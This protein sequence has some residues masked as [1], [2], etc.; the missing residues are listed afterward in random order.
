M[1]AIEH[2]HDA[3]HES[4][5]GA[6]PLDDCW[7]RIGTRGD[8]SCERLAQYVRCLNCPVFE[9][10]A[11]RM[12]DRPAQRAAR[13]PEPEGG[14]AAQA[15]AARQEG[16]LVFRVGAE[17]LALGAQALRYVGEARAIHSLPHRR[18]PAVLGVVNVRGV[19]TLAASLAELLRIDVT[20]D[21]TAAA[22][23]RFAT[24]GAGAAGAAGARAAT[25]R[26]LVAEWGGETTA[27]PVDDVEGVAYF[28]K[29]D[30]LS[31]PATLAHAA[32]RHVRG[33]FAW[34]GRSVG[35]LD[36]DALFGALT[37][38]LR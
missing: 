14:R 23:A 25:P 17:W 19:L 24:P 1:H 18:S 9:A 16:S 22:A 35:V 31:A 38:S 3:I 2:E 15:G 6:A 7:N 34:R 30:L 5:A 36:P 21:A 20:A 10:A 32:G 8:G 13:A 37:R 4:G 26:L 27:F 12:L 29:D 11:A 33:V 28:G